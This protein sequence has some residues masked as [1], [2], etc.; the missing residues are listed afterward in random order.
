MPGDDKGR[1]EIAAAAQKHGLTL[2]LLYGGGD[3]DVQKHLSQFKEGLNAA[4][5][6]KP[7][8]INCHSGRD[9]LLTSK[10]GFLL[11]SPP[12]FRNKPAYPFITKRIAVDRCMPHR[13]QRI[14]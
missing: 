9:F 6:M 13:L 3:K 10:T 12:S 8:Y 4:V 7:I 5:K 2:G 14:L 11:I 1:S